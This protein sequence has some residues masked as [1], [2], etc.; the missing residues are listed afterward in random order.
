M[1]KKSYILI[2]VAKPDDSNSGSLT[3]EKELVFNV[4][5]AEWA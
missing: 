2:D 4:Q 5:E 3:P 1:I